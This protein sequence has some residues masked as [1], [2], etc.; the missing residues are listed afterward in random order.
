MIWI[1]LAGGTG[2]AG[3]EGTLRGPRGPK[4]GLNNHG[5]SDDENIVTMNEMGMKMM[6]VAAMI[7]PSPP[8]HR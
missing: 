2:R 5:I 6:M 3:I 4:N 7:I 8:F 1:F